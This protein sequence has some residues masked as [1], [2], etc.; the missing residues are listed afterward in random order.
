MHVVSFPVPVVKWLPVTEFEWTVK[1]DRYDYKYEINSTIHIKT[2][3]DFREYGIEICNKLGCILENI[4]V[5]AEGNY[6]LYII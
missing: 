5:I 6:V 2:E 1:K 3:K 4:T